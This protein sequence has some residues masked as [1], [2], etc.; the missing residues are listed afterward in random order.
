MRPVKCP[1]CGG[2]LLKDL[3]IT[4]TAAGSFAFAS[5]CPACKAPFTFEV[6]TELVAVVFVNGDRQGGDESTG[7][8]MARLL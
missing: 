4:G 7:D 3:I 1:A 8:A 5:R 6:K 2:P